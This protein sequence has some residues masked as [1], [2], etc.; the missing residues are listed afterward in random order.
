MPRSQHPCDQVPDPERLKDVPPTAFVADLHASD[1]DPA[2]MEK[3]MPFVY[4]RARDIAVQVLVGDRAGQWVDASSLVQRTMVRLLGQ[5]RVDL[6]DAARLSGVLATIMRR[7]VVD[8]ARHETA[9][10]R[11]GGVPVISL[12]AM[13]G[14][15]QSRHPARSVS[16]LE[17]DDA[18]GALA[19]IDPP[20]ARVAEMRLWGGMDLVAISS[21]L[22]QTYANTRTLWN[23]AKAW[24]AQ[25]LAGGRD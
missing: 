16:A 17:L 7:I 19:R 21:A 2:T 25:E 10:K 14:H 15:G 6:A 11:G 1:I 13:R 9:D 18:L 4:E 22:G 23:Y 12:H 24:L 8:I 3:L 20:A 5:E